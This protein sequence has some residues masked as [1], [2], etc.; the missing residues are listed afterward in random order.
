MP[1]TTK[2]AAVLGGTAFASATIGMVVFRLLLLRLRSHHVE[3]WKSLG[4]PRQFSSPSP[5][6]H[7]EWIW[8]SLYKSLEDRRLSFLARMY[9]VLVV[10]FWLGFFVA[11]ALVVG[12]EIVEAM[13]S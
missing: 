13:S 11:F 9:K 2:L 1:L 12:A 6:L 10:V 7:R 3:E 5:G 8:R 4:S